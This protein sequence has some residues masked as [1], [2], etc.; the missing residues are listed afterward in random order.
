VAQRVAFTL[1][2]DLS[3]LCFLHQRDERGQEIVGLS[4]LW[5]LGIAVCAASKFSSSIVV[6]AAMPKLEIPELVEITI[7]L[8]PDET[9]LGLQIRQVG[10]TFHLSDFVPYF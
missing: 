3:I 6:E 7:Q 1:L 2:A 10:S 9:S 4:N 5:E 8:L